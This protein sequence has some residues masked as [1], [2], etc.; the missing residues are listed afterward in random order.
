MVKLLKKFAMN[1]EKH[2]HVSKKEKSQMCFPCL[3]PLFHLIKGKVEERYIKLGKGV[4][5]F[6]L[7]IW[8][9]VVEM[10]CS[11]CL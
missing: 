3:T 11:L 9:L 10:P 2:V 8:I 4:A 7:M 5:C 1:I 6:K